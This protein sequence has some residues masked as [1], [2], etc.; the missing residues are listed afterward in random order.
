MGHPVSAYDHDFS[1]M[2]N[3]L[4]L[5]PFDSTWIMFDILV[6]HK[7]LNGAIMFHEIIMFLLKL[8]TSVS[9][10]R[11]RSLLRQRDKN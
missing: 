10:R 2:Q 5:R 4:N 1:D 6:T 8:N 11:N 3:Q 9:L 7:I